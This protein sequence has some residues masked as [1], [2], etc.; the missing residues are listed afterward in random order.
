M[1][2]QPDEGGHWLLVEH[3]GVK[4]ALDFLMSTTPAFFERRPAVF[5]QWLTDDGEPDELV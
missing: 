5:N 1:G 3:L 2:W 4:R